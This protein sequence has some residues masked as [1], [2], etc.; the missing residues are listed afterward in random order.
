MEDYSIYDDQ[1][2]GFGHESANKGV[3]KRS[4]DV[5]QAQ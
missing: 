4:K 1:S 3:N 2:S 5:T